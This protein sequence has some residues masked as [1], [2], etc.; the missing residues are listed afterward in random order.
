MLAPAPS[1]ICAAGLHI[2]HLPRT[3]FLLVSGSLGRGAENREMALSAFASAAGAATLNYARTTGGSAAATKL[4]AQ[5]NEAGEDAAGNRR[6]LGELRG[7]DPTAL[8]QILLHE[9]GQL[10]TTAETSSAGAGVAGG[11]KA[12]QMRRSNGGSGG[13]E[14]GPLI[15]PLKRRRESTWTRSA[16]TAH[17]TSIWLRLG[18]SVAVVVHVARQEA[19]VAHAHAPGAARGTSFRSQCALGAHRVAP[20]GQRVVRPAPASGADDALPRVERLEYELHLPFPSMQR[21]NTRPPR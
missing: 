19:R 10:S 8:R 16:S 12:R 21:Y 1:D 20:R 17:T 13:V 14:D 7:K 11:N 4:L 18:Y 9:S 5:L 2:L 6:T 15:A 3:P